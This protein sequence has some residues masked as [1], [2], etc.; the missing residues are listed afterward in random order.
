MGS[1][2]DLIPKQKVR[3]DKER[4]LIS[5]YQILASTVL[6]LSPS[7][8]TPSLCLSSFSP[9]S[10]SGKQISY[11]IHFI[12]VL[13]FLDER[14]AYHIASM[15]NK[16]AWAILISDNAHFKPKDVLQG[17]LLKRKPIVIGSG[18]TGEH[19]LHAGSEAVWVSWSF[20]QWEKDEDKRQELRFS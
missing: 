4:H 8:P 10:F 19:N 17:H 11:Q 13:I 18:H 1:V 5:K 6:S 9:S 15:Q 16:A 7:L 20:S 14:K 2:K 12:T 3:S